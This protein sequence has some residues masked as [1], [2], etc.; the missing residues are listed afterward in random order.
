MFSLIIT[1][2][3]IALVA[4]LAL[5]TLYYGGDAFNKGQAQAQA[6]KVR[7]QGQQLLGAAELFKANHGR[8]P[9]NVAEMVT[10]KYLSSVPVARTAIAEALADSAWYM[11][12]QE[13]ALFLLSTPVPEA[14]R[15][16]NEKGYGQRGIL[17][18]VVDGVQ[19]QCYG[20]AL[21]ALYTMAAK[22]PKA[23]QALTGAAPEAVQGAA[24]APQLVAQ[25]PTAEDDAAWLVSHSAPVVAPPAPANGGDPDPEPGSGGEVTPAPGVLTTAS[26]TWSFDTQEA[27]TTAV[28]TF[29]FQNT[30]GSP[31]PVAAAQVTGA[32]FS[33]TADNCV[34]T[35]A[36]E[37]SCDVSVEFAPQSA[38][39]H[40]ATLTVASA[41]ETRTVALTGTSVVPSAT[42]YWTSNYNDTLEVSGTSFAQL[43]I[44]ATAAK[45]FYLRRTGEGTLSASFALQGAD[46]AHFTLATAPLAAQDGSSGT[47]NCGAT[48]TNGGASTTECAG[49]ESHPNLRV[50]I[51]Y[52]PAAAGSHTA[53]LVA[54]SGNGSTLPAAF[55]LAGTA[56]APLPAGFVQLGSRTYT[57]PSATLAW[58]S[59]N[60]YCAN[61]VAWGQSDWRLPTLTEA[62]DLRFAARSPGGSLNLVT[63]GWTSTESDARYWTSA[64]SSGGHY[65]MDFSYN[66]TSPTSGQG[67]YS[68]VNAFRASCVR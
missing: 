62:N 39:D 46:A 27:G 16:I 32:G 9:I 60:T 64:V 3:S 44:G 45:T 5:A 66:G 65:S 33:V 41:Q 40:S 20:P 26:S 7:N 29:T 54:T 47:D 4:A 53:Q 8:Y 58:G 12:L 55:T 38:G 2:I 68:D 59:A 10:D 13:E 19:V 34:G 25:L 1:I 56:Q 36:V 22:D 67:S 50:T 18:G 43:N 63:L 6:A 42:G 51:T 61:L 48:L 14:C 28:K 49:T 23:V 57:K 35:L 11:P 24:P 31:L 17:T 52:A 15:T 37:Q 30:G 21:N